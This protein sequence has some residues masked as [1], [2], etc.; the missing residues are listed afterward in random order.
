MEVYNVDVGQGV[1]LRL[2]NSNLARLAPGGGEDDDG[3][4][5]E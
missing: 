4:G 5:R 2:W 3:Q 1:S